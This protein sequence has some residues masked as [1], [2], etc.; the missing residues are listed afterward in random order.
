MPAGVR[1]RRC[2]HPGPRRPATPRPGNAQSPTGPA[3]TGPSPSEPG[4][5]CCDRR[6][7]Q[8]VGRNPG[9]RRGARAGGGRCSLG[10]RWS[11]NCRG[12]RGWGR[13]GRGLGGDRHAGGACCRD[14]R[15]RGIWTVR[16]RRADQRRD[17]SSD[18]VAGGAGGR[19]CEDQG[20]GCQH[21]RGR[22]GVA[23]PFC[24]LHPIH[25]RGA[26]GAGRGP[27]RGALA[28]D[29]PDASR[30]RRGGLPWRRVDSAGGLGPGPGAAF[31]LAARA[32]ANPGIRWKPRTIQ[33]AVRGHFEGDFSPRAGRSRRV[34]CQSCPRTRSQA[35]P[36]R[37]KETAP[38]T[39]PGPI[40]EDQ[41]F[42]PESNWRPS[43]Y[44]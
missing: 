12:A 7:R 20:R 6:G 31:L 21:Q 32:P 23:G 28:A 13:S 4:W 10:A 22:D 40:L 30:N 37:A 1:R 26:E 17:D 16:G 33:L 3:L 41:S 29:R 9:R 24:G 19:Q 27:W 35:G 34:R 39:A 42:L 18:G 2:G 38:T 14:R 5:P 36:K 44:E 25:R 8:M 15:C 43:H 11:R